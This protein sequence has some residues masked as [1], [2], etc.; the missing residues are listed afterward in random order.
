MDKDVNTMVRQAISGG[1]HTLIRLA[2]GTILSGGAC[3][4]GWCRM[5][6]L[7]E[8]LYGW[9]KVNGINEN[10]SKVYASYYHNLAIGAQ[11]GSLYT[12]GCG[13]FV[14]GN[15]DGVIPSLGPNLKEDLGGPP[16]HVAIPG[17]VLDIS[18][19]AY[20]SI[21]LND[22][23]N[24]YTF[25]AGQ[26]GQLGR[27]LSKSPSAKVDGAGLPIDATPRL[28]EG[29]KE[30][31]T[32]E[33]IGASFY[34]TF[35][36]CKSGTVYCAGE[37]QNMQCGKARNAENSK[38]LHQMEAINELIDENIKIVKAVGGYCHNLMLDDKGHVISMGCGDDGNRG[39]GDGEKYEESGKKRS[40]FNYVELPCPAEDIATGANHSIVLGTDGNCYG[41]GSNEYGQLGA[42]NVTQTQGLRNNTIDDDDDDDDDSNSYIFAPARINLPE[43]AGKVVSISA[44]YAHT[45]I[46]DENGDVYIFGQNENGQLGLGKVGLDIPFV[47]NP[48]KVVYES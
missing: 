30:E 8:S 2:N 42:H 12:W 21:V 44:G 27:S 31:E 43:N 13:T 35:V 6:D 33:S 15:N 16:A 45:T 37:N 5:Q 14:D 25:G 11:T 17:K 48:T 38:N 34:N 7:N 40:I 1:E 39:D 24:V 28:V 46:L 41:F 10:V 36:T 29:L 3:G 32:V 9:R 47:F 20:H 4:L 19:G 22:A 18:G 26:L 23:G